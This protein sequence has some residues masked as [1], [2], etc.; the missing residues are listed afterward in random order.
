MD[1]NLHK[2]PRNPYLGF[3]AKEE[4][5]SVPVVAAR[6]GTDP[7]ESRELARCE[8]SLDDAARLGAVLQQITRIPG[9]RSARRR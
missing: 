1:V 7:L 2:I 9:V 6:G 8:R 4:L 5:L 3:D